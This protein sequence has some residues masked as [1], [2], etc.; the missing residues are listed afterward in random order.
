MVVLQIMLLISIVVTGGLAAA[1]G[2]KEG[3]EEESHLV[4]PP[5]FVGAFIVGFTV[6]T[7]THELRQ[8]INVMKTHCFSIIYSENRGDITKTRLFKHI[9]N[10]TTKKAKFSDKKF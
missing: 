2:Q 7:T 8:H 1:D 10:F 5:Y 3:S 4:G 6:R 9:E